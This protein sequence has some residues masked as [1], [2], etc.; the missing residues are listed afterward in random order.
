MLNIYIY[1]DLFP[2]TY[3]C[4]KNKQ[5]K[6][7]KTKTNSKQNKTH[8]VLWVWSFVCFLFV[9]SGGQNWPKF[10]WKSW[11]EPIILLKLFWVIF[12]N[13]QP[14]SMDFVPQN[15]WFNL[16]LEKLKIETKNLP[17]MQNMGRL[18]P[19]KQGVFFFFIYFVLV[20]FSPYLHI[21][22]QHSNKIE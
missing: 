6:Q 20:F 13:F 15:G 12:K 3:R 17:K 5:N 16:I 22:Q 18:V 2:S 4:R 8:P 9:F 7:T 21:Y 1:N 11:T 14:K 19:W 10:S